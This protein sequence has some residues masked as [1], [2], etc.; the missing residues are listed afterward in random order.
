MS[1]FEITPAGDRAAGRAR[2]ED[3]GVL[4]RIGRAPQRYDAPARVARVRAR[5]A[6]ID[7]PLD[8]ERAGARCGGCRLRRASRCGSNTRRRSAPCPRGSEL[9]VLLC[10]LPWRQRRRRSGE[11]RT[12]AGRT[13]RLVAGPA[14]H[15]VSAGGPKF[16][17][18]RKGGSRA[19]F[20]RVE[21]RGHRGDCR[22]SRNSR[23]LAGRGALVQTRVGCGA[24]ALSCESSADISSWL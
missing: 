13:E 4:P 16:R 21:C 6:W 10:R 24:F 20:R 14:A 19:R 5:G 9:R 22:V 11:A 12:R 15:R 1:G 23:T 17:R 7:V 18:P 2:L 8:A 3:S